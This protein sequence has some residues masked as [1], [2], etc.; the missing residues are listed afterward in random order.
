MGNTRPTIGNPIP[1]SP[2]DA[3]TR[4]FKFDAD[5]ITDEILDERRASEFFVAV[6]A[7]KK[8]S[9]KQ[10]EIDFLDVSTER[11]ETN[12]LINRI[13]SRV[14]RWR[15][16]GYPGITPTTRSLLDHW[17]NPERERRRFFCQ[18]EAIETAI[19]LAEAAAKSNDVWIENAVRDANDEANPGLYRVAHK[20]ATGTGK[21]V[22]M[23]MLIAWHTLNK[24]AD[25]RN[26]A[27][28]DAFLVVCPGITIRDRLRVLLPSDPANYYRGMDLVPADRLADLGTA[29][30][31][32]TNFHAF[33][34]RERISAPKTTKAVLLPHG[35]V[36]GVFTE[37]PDHM[38]RRVLRDLGTKRQIVVLNDEAHH[39]YRRKPMAAENET[40]DDLNALKG[41]EKSEAK[42][43]DDEARIWLS[44]LEAI[45]N[46]VGIRAIHDLSATPFFLKGSGWPEGTL[47]PWVVSDFG[48]IDAIEAGLVKIPR[49]SRRSR[50]PSRICCS[51]R[52]TVRAIRRWWCQRS[53]TRAT[54]VRA[55]STSSWAGWWKL[56]SSTD[57][58][59]AST[60]TP[61]RSSGSF[62][63]GGCRQQCD[64][65]TGGSLQLSPGCAARNAAHTSGRSRP[66]HGTSRPAA[67]AHARTSAVVGS[68]AGTAP[69]RGSAAARSCAS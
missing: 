39:C 42:K 19:Y 60:N 22:I 7:P 2:Y 8:K 29:K 18:L 28:G 69:G 25:P 51:P 41:E 36:A 24:V 57:F 55:T 54:S 30:V 61:P 66:P 40:V 48:L 3:P 31:V 56:A 65:P 46:K 53:T 4:C 20:M 34:L 15:E 12:E 44:G 16:F 26:K 10:Q 58:G 6:P 9:G 38:V 17:H 21:T 13:R 32:I 62:L 68:A 63:N 64:Q 43:R 14:D 23:A 1:N 5:G 45:Q 67:R 27:F 52:W 35:D 47:F 11:V 59:R 33:K 50:R 49:E 37:T